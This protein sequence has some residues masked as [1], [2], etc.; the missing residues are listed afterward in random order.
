MCGGVGLVKAEECNLGGHVRVIDGR[1]LT[2]GRAA[3]VALQLGIAHKHERAQAE[4]RIVWNRNVAGARWKLQVI[5]VA[6]T[7]VDPLFLPKLRD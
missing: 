1:R 3:K 2:T 6:E 4:G 7:R 5:E